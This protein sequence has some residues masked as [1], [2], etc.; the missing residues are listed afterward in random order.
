LEAP[1]GNSLPVLQTIDCTKQ[2]TRIAFSPDGRLLAIGQVG[3]IALYNPATGEEVAPFK[4]TPAAVLGLA[5]SPDSRHLASADISDPAIKVWDVAANEPKFE[6]RQPPSSPRSLAISPNGRLIA[7]PGPPKA[8][9][10]YTVN[11][12][13]MLDWDAKTSKTPYQLRYTLSGHSGY[14][15]KLTFS[16]DGRYLAS[17]SWDLTIKIWDLEALEKDS[18]A[19]PVTLRG[20]SSF[21][22]GLAFSPDGRHLATSSGSAR[23]GELKVWD[24]AGWENKADVG[25]R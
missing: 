10:G 21:S 14:A 13:E 11:I 9:A 8:I 16:H 22:Y 15:E 19:K 24:A 1:I 12:W 4:P 6:I 20:H 2:V 18:K 5:F 25:D 7:V 17:G 3:G 23:H